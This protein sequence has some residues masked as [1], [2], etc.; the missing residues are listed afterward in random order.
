MDRNHGLTKTDT[1]ADWALVQDDAE[2]RRDAGLQ[3]LPPPAH[4]PVAHRVRTGRDPSGKRGHLIRGHLIRGH[5]IRGQP[6]GPA[7][8]A[9]LS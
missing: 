8:G 4:H 1:L 7:A 6:P 5:L 2:H 9:G 3:I